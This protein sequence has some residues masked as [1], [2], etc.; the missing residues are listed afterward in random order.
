MIRRSIAGL[1]AALVLVPFCASA[2]TK[3]HAPHWGYQGA[4]GPAHW[5]AMESEFRS[6]GMGHEQSPVDIRPGQAQR[7]DL[8][9]IRFAYGPSPLRI[10]DNGHTI[11]VNVA[12]GRFIDVGG[13]RY[14]LL[15][16]HFHRPSEE[17]I[18]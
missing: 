9:A 11:Q 5:A 17:S 16:F 13:H 3:G 6:C 2:A 10:V 12:P 18:D 15:Q 1:W 14:E 7:T 4:G 8:P